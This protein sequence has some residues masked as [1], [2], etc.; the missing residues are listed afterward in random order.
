MNQ[1]SS[2]IEYC[3]CIDLDDTL[4]NE[5][6][7]V[8]SGYKAIMM[9]LKKNKKIKIA[10]LPNKKEILANKKKPYTNFS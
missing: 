10:K 2:Q 8:L 9:H 7:Y 1:K 4:Y 6:D 5:V 3:L